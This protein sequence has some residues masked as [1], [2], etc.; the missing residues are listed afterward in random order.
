MGKLIFTNDTEYNREA[1]KIEFTLPEDMDIFEYRIMCI[2]MASA[3]GYGPQSIKRAFG[4]EDKY[5][6]QSD[7]D[8]KKFLQSIN[9]YT[10]SLLNEFQ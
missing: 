2:R 8:F 6:T 10:G 4:E 7:L 3:M 5:E 9:I 1:S